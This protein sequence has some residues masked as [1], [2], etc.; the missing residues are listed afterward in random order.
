M[1]VWRGLEFWG[2]EPVTLMIRKSSLSWSGHMECKDNIE[3]LKCC[4]TD[5]GGDS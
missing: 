4:T 5:H 3:W 2:L 1:W